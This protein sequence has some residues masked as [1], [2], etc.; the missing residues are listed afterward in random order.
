ML[1]RAAQSRD[2]IFPVRM[3]PAVLFRE[4]FLHRVGQM[5]G[6]TRTEPDL[7]AIVSFLVEHN[8]KELT[9]FFA[10]QRTASTRGWSLPLVIGV[11]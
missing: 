10:A 5:L 8:H 4:Q 7:N 6:M 2:A 11:K 1:K 3:I 9:R